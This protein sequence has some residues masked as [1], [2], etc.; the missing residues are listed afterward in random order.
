[1]NR[2]LSLNMEALSWVIRTDASGMIH[3]HEMWSKV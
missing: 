1:M 2:P 3:I